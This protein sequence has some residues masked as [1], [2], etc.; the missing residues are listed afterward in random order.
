MQFADRLQFL[1]SNVFAEM[2][3][4]KRT[5][6][7]AGKEVID[8]SLGASDLPAP[9]QAIQTI[10]QS[11]EAADCNAYVLF[12]ATREFRVAVAQWLEQKFG[13][14]ADP[15]TEILPL[16]GSQEG[17]AHLP[18]AILNQ[19][20]YAL[21][22]DPGYPAHFGGVYLAGGQVYSMPLLPENRFFPDFAA[23]PQPVLAQ[24]KLMILSYPHNPT[25]ALVPLN[26]LESAVKFCQEHNLVLMHDAPYI[27]LV[28]ANSPAPV[29]LQA[30]RSKSVTVEFFTLSKS[31]HMGGFRIGFA[32]GNA[33]IIKALRQIKS[34]I[35]FNQYGGILQGAITALQSPPELLRETIEIF[36]QRRDAMVK[37]FHDIGWPVPIP[38]ATLYI[39]AKLPDFIQL[40]SIT[41]C[42]LLVE[43]TGVALAPGRGF[44][45]YGEGFVRI[46]LVRSPEVLTKVVS[47]IQTFF[48]TYRS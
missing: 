14:S 1:G 31:Y 45:K 44:G 3:T 30:D 12:A 8:L 26:L 36:Q 42:K 10:A 2:D 29:M 13:V 11:L 4:A 28:F 48:Q 6:Q 33:E 40:D 16:I 43:Q 22:Q 9:A 23:I 17:I 38:S 46:A 27:D 32:V 24:S 37:A 7:L 20:D 34:V 39:W 15:E 19:G 21:L 35:D 25:S 18:L 5:A 41:F 47:Q